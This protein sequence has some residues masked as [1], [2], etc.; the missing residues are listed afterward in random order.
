MHTMDYVDL[1]MLFLAGFAGGYTIGR[2]TQYE[3]VARK[4]W[5]GIARCGEQMKENKNG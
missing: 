4:I 5:D 3:K 1:I 2:Y